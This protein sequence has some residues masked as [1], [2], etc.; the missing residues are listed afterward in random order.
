MAWQSVPLHLISMLWG[1][2]FQFNKCQICFKA[3][4]EKK[5]FFFLTRKWGLPGTEEAG[6]GLTPSGTWRVGLHVSSVTFTLTEFV[7]RMEHLCLS[8]DDMGLLT[9]IND[10]ASLNSSMPV[11]REE[12]IM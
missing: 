6:L 5:S 8:T 7:P 9:V 10:A 2:K 12:E 4:E 3:Q 1:K 11:Y